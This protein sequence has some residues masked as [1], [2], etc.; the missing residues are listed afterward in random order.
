MADIE[1]L[2]NG[3]TDEND[4]HAYSCLKELEELSEQSNEVYKYFDVFVEMLSNPS[5]YIRTRGF[6]LI[7]ANARW[8]EDN[9]IDEIIDTILECIS[10]EKP[11]TARQCIKALP[12]LAK[13]KSELKE[14]IINALRRINVT[15]YAESM[16]SLV[17]KDVSEALARITKG[18]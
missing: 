16:Q 4:T 18:N 8:D 9:G 10:D 7:A 5:S 11:I 14:D 6:L 12:I 2:V 15:I 1:N 17:N 13:H 3:L